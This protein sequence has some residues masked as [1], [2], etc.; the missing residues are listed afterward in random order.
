M[1]VRRLFL[2]F[3]AYGF[4]DF[5]LGGLGF[6]IVMPLLT[7]FVTPAEYGIVASLNAINLMLVSIMQF[8][9][10]SAV[11]RYYFLYEKG[12]SRNAFFGSMWLFSLFLSG[13]MLL[14]FQ[15]FG[16]STWDMLIRVAPFSVYAQYVISSA[17][18][19]ISAIFCSVLLRAQER[20]RLF[21]L[22]SIAQ[23]LCYIVLI[24][25]HVVVLKQGALGQVKS[26]FYSSLLFASISAIIL[27]SNLRFQPQL[28]HFRESLSFAAP[29]FLTYLIGF[30]VTRANVL[31][32]QYFVVGGIVGIFALGVQLSNIIYMISG[33]FEKAWQPFLYSLSPDRARIVLSQYLRFSV[34]IF[35]F[36]ALVM[37]LFASEIIKVL[38]T[39]NYSE[40]WSVVAITAIGTACVAIS[41]VPAGAIYYAKQSGFIAWVT[42]AMAII[43]VGINLLLIPY[44]GMMGAVFTNMLVGIG[45]LIFNMWGMHKY[46]KIKVNYQHFLTTIC[47]G[48]IILIIGSWGG[49]VWSNSIIFVSLTIKCLLLLC[50]CVLLWLFGIFP[51]KEDRWM[52]PYFMSIIRIGPY[53]IQNKVKNR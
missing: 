51:S 37:G 40:A 50:F 28:R 39:R 33:A 31:I 26:S 19:Q 18:F 16:R 2:G 30:F 5:I 20:P 9:I 15:L 35:I 7:H 10:P 32:L 52:W 11:F 48:V 22:M 42:F 38:A 8:G 44:L 21:V 17:F 3:A 29:I 36:L 6:F 25:Y 4:G 13:L 43:N 45:T 46:L 27:I 34:L 47:F 1:K 12:H 53:K 14:I 23:A 49:I 24:Y 41:A